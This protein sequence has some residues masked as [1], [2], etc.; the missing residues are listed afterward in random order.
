[1]FEL[2]LSLKFH[3]ILFAQFQY[4]GFSVRIE[5]RMTYHI[6]PFDVTALIQHNLLDSRLHRFEL[7]ALQQ[8]V[9]LTEANVHHEITFIPTFNLK[10]IV[11]GIPFLTA[12]I[13]GESPSSLLESTIA[14]FLINKSAA[15]SEPK[16]T[17]IMFIV[18]LIK[19]DGI[20][21]FEERK[22]K[23][24]HFE[25]RSVAVSIYFCSKS[26]YSLHF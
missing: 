8:L 1:M 15:L 7:R 24:Y 21:F 13:S 16:P 19:V 22:K 5:S 9:Y 6:R 20:F 26:W 23:N 2:V 25:L 14:P 4:F 10:T 3:S 11:F 18:H 17:N 12:M